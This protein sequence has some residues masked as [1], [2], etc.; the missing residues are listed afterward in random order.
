M[1]KYEEGFA[2][3]LKFVKKI[4]PSVCPNLGFE[5]QL[6]KY[7]E[8]LSTDQAN[9]PRKIA[10]QVSQHEQGGSRNQ[11]LEAKHMMLTFNCPI[12][13]SKKS[14]MAA[15]NKTIS[16]HTPPVIKKGPRFSSQKRTKVEEGG[17]F[18]EGRPAIGELKSEMVYDP[19]KYWHRGSMGGRRKENSCFKM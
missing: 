16:G 18:V 4:R 3:A 14:S 6:K 15:T 17:L 2:N 13:D 12:K 10:K 1:K 19:E 5:L 8:K 9:R 7:Q 11:F